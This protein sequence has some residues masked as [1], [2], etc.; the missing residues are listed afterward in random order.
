[1]G[2]DPNRIMSRIRKLFSVLVLVI[3]WESKQLTGTSKNTWNTLFLVSHLI[4][5]L[6]LKSLECSL[7][8]PL[9]IIKEPANL[10]KPQTVS[11][12][13]SK[14]SA[15]DNLPNELKLMILEH[16]ES[17]ETLSNMA[18]VN[19]NWNVL[20][21]QLLYQCPQLTSINS[22]YKFVQNVNDN[23]Y[24]RKSISAIRFLPTSVGTLS[25]RPYA[26]HGSIPYTHSGKP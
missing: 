5:H 4:C 20:C 23:Q 8:S 1:M 22:I 10:Q 3:E 15:L 11:I 21:N 18:L 14:D 12:N 17:Q 7:Q 6:K 16:L 2:M 24:F 13:G 9:E 26:K 19:K 25:G